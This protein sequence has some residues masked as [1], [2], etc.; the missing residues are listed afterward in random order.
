[1]VPE[2]ELIKVPK[3]FS[4]PAVS[5]YFGGRLG[6]NRSPLSA[7]PS[8]R[9]AETALESCPASIEQ[10]Q[11]NVLL[12]FCTYCTAVEYPFRI[13]PPILQSSTSSR[14]M[15]RV[16]W[17]LLSDFPLW[18]VRMEIVVWDQ[19]VKLQLFCISKSELITG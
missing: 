10:Y 7:R 17:Y 3:R 1:M 4:I 16:D 6:G 19:S 2:S 11:A 13:N 12:M 14:A 18:K 5:V 9:V 15:T 8:R